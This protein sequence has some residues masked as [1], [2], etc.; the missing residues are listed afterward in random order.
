MIEIAEQM[1]VMPPAHRPTLKDI[2]KASGVSLA[3]ASAALNEKQGVAPETRARVLEVAT[4]L[5]YNLRGKKLTRP[6]AEL[7][8]IGLVIKHDLD[9]VRGA[10]P[11]YSHVQFGVSDFCQRHNISLMVATMDVDVSNHPIS[12]PAMI[13]QNHID[14]LIL[15][16]AFIDDTV[17]II[18][19]KFD[20]PIVLVDSYS[21]TLQCDSVVT[22]NFGGARKAV[23]YL[24]KNGHERIGLAGWNPL[25]PPSIQLRQQGYLRVL[26]AYGLKPFI[27]ET[28]LSRAGGQKAATKLLASNPQVTALFCC[29]DE[30]A[31][32]AISAIR[33]LGLE[34]PR[35]VSVV[36]FDNIDLAAEV[37]PAL[38][39]VHVHKTW[40]GAL[41]V[42]TL[43]ERVQH[44][45]KPKTTIVM[46]TDLIVRHSVACIAAPDPEKERKGE[47]A[48][49]EMQY[50]I[51]P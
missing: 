30:T 2:A 8:I 33:Q 11:F 5:G 38:T 25:S 22:D 36:G 41:G 19:R 29:N 27:V 34:V 50:S 4:S 7:K 51:M 49:P 37:S 16:G 13:T 24:V 47:L 18:K 12:W 26:N 40:M 14:G 6:E 35:D 23:E 46:D 10:N 17:E 43:I 32:G 44:P 45:D 28:Q 3:T 21:S 48:L 20:F 9:V 1:P 15:A 39:T 42:Q 31:I